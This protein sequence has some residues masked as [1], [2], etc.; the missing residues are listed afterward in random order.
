MGCIGKCFFCCFATALLL[1]T[2][3][4]AMF[5]P[6][7]ARSYLHV[8]HTSTSGIFLWLLTGFGA[9]RDMSLFGPLTIIDMTI[10]ARDLCEYL[11]GYGG[12]GL[13]LAVDLVNIPHNSLMRCS[14][15]AVKEIHYN[16]K[17]K[18]PYHFFIGVN[19]STVP[20]GYFPEGLFPRFILQLSTD[21]PE[22]LERRDLMVGT[23]PGLSRG[24][25]QRPKT[26]PGVSVKTISH[27]PFQS[28][29]PG[30]NLFHVPFPIKATAGFCLFRRAFHIELTEVQLKLL[31]EWATVLTPVAM[32]MGSIAG[33]TRAS[34]IATIFHDIVSESDAGKKF[35]ARAAS[36]GMDGPLRMREMLIAFVFAGYGAPIGIIS[37]AHQAILKIKRDSKALVPLFKQDPEAFV[38]EMLRH[39]LGASGMNPFAVPETKSYVLGTGRKFTE[40]VGM[41][42]TIAIWGANADPE[43]FGGPSKDLSHAKEFIPGRENADRVLSFAAELR[44]IRQCPNMTG[45]EVAPRFCLGAE[46]AL[47]VIEDVLSLVLESME[48]AGADEL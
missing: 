20:A 11:G 34:E 26:P 35:L 44:D 28:Y 30:G 7:V 46:L 5:I 41:Y 27:L 1:V 6:V 22:R 37:T 4:G 45:C 8:I 16:P 15:A 48:M 10:Q 38:I 25:V 19:T 33:G 47:K 17:L 32:G 43:V 42:G 31:D 40:T 29:L 36:R 21:D 39:T 13:V 3:L 9:M 18:R 12:N 23:I 2:F 14:H 24:P